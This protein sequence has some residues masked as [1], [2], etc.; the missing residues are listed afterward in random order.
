MKRI[1]ITFLFALSASLFTSC[2]EEDQ[3][4]IITNPEVVV[5]PASLE[6]GDLNVGEE[7]APQMI[8]VSIFDITGNVTVTIPEH[9]QVSLEEADEYVSDELTIEGSNAVLY[10]KATPPASFQGNLAGDLAFITDDAPEVKVSLSA[11]VAIEITGTLLM[12]EYFE[13]YSDWSG[14]MPLDSGILSWDLNTDTVVNA[15]NSGVGYPETTIS[16]NE[17]T[18]V[19]YHPIPL[20][21]ATLRSS[22]GLSDDSNLSFAGYPTVDGYRNINIDPAGSWHF[23]KWINKKNG[24]CGGF[25]EQGNNTSAARRFALDGN[26]NDLFMSVLINVNTLGSARNDDELGI[27][28]LIALANA[29]SGSANNNVVKIVAINDGQG[30]FNFG[31]IKGDEGSAYVL[32]T[33]SYEIGETYAVVL[34]HEFVEGD[35]NDVSNLYVFSSGEVIPT[36]MN[37]L[38]PVAT[39]DASSDGVGLDP[40]DL[41]TVFIR[42]RTQSVITPVASFTGIRVGDSWVATLFAE[43]SAAQNSNDISLHNRVLTNVGSSC[44]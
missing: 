6:F 5:N 34:S 30:G 4:Q 3:K 21:G 7:S 41:T 39:I 22:V 18:N 23:F 28:D 33:E 10:V 8:E 17:V 25:K 11:R 2:S 14:V 35:N 9:F 44:E 29:T 12:S 24:N 1:I 19:W 36:S 31:L 43:H 26:T 16:N 20:N 42:E 32:S 13:Q 37:G 40:T 15:S 27:G 38:S